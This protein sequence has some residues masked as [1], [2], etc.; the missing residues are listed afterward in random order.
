MDYD[1]PRHTARISPSPGKTRRALRLVGWNVLFLVAGLAL[2]GVV[3]EA[4]FRLRTPFVENVHPYLWSPTVGG[5]YIPNAEVRHTNGLD[6]WT[7]S[8]T[9]SLGFPDREPIGIERATASCHIAMIGDSYVEALQVPIADKFHVRLEELAAR[10]LRHLDITTSAFGIAGTGQVNQLAYYDEFARPLRPALLV[11]VFVNN[12]FMNNAPILDGLH[13]GMDPDRLKNVSAIRGADGSITLRPPYPG[14]SRFAEMPPP[15]PPLWFTRATDHLTGISPLANWLDAKRR[16]SFS[17]DP[18]PELPAWVALLSRRSPRYAAL[19][20]GW[21]PTTREGIND[22]FLYAQDMPPVYEDALDF[23]AFALDQFKERADRDGAALVILS[24]HYM[25]TRGDLGF[26]RL[27]AL[28]EPRGIPV[29]DY[30]A[31][32]LRQGAVPWRDAGWAHDGHWNVAGHRWAAEVLLEYLKQNQE[33]CTRRKNP[34][35]PPPPPS[36]RTDYESIASGEPAARS[37]FDIYL[38]ENT[39]AYLKS[40]CSAADVQAPFFLH[41]VPEDVEDLPAHRQQYGFDNLDFHYGGNAALTFGGMCIAKRPLPDYPIVRIRT[42]QYIPGEDPIWQAEFPVGAGRDEAAPPP[43]P[44]WRKDYE[45]IASGEPVARSDFD[46]YLRENTVSYLKSPCS[47]ADVQAPFF[48]HVVPEDV[49]DLPAHRQQYGFDNLDFHYGGNAALT[50]GGMC[51]AKRPLPDYP[52]VRI[53]TGQFIPGEDPI[54][55]AEFPVGAGRD[56][57]APPPLPSWRKDYESIASGEP[58]ARSD[59]DIYLRENTVS[60]LK[61]PCSAAD[62]Q[63]PFFLHVVPEDVEDLPAHRQQYGFDNLD[64]HYGGNAALT[65][66][67][68][69]IAKRPLPD[70]PIVRIR[71][72]QFIPGEDPIWQAEFPV[73]AGRDEAA[74]RSASGRASGR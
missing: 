27:T 11:L 56:E 14:E 41:V 39:V 46:I 47:A 43:L 65:L 20:D 50:L 32:V 71:T 1:N 52:I 73:G 9:N 21:R 61:S 54:W 51:I 23:T 66:G 31:Y 70:Y 24:T 6:F 48:L 53:R 69:C 58:A 72:G 49:E 28:A 63:A 62:V 42:G 4:Y 55:Q 36:W 34:A 16:A 18:D 33:V 17:D 3:G 8:R 25:G 35:S 38:R 57:A 67:G 64:F 7:I 13:R 12:D 26:D 15:P 29:I 30:H 60:Y 45:S 19:L 22:P 74:A 59:F 10:E 68:M 44:S 37:D 40:P 2:I 5:I